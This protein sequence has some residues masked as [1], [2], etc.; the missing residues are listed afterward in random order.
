MQKLKNHLIQN[1]QLLESEVKAT[2]EILKQNEQLVKEV[3]ELKKF[4]QTHKTT[5]G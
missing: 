4:H 1:Q 3:E 5:E 2:Q